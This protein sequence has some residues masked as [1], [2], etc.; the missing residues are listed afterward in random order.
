MLG[1]FHASAQM[2]VS[3]IVFDI[4]K[5][6]YVEN[7]KV[8]ST[9]GGF[10]L[11]DSMGR[12]HILVHKEDSLYFFYNNKPTL[13]FAVSQI[14][15]P[16]QFNIS[17]SLAVKSKYSLLKE[18]TVIA[19]SYRE[20][21]IENRETYSNVFNFT[22]PGLQS[23]MSPDGIPGAD[24]GALINVFRFRYSKRMRKFRERLEAQEQEKYVDYRFNKTFVRRITGLQPPALDT[25]MAWYRPDYHFTR[26]ADELAFNQYILNSLYHFRKIRGGGA[27][28]AK[29]E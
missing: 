28:P 19:R 12:Y 17:L 25:F 29:K 11:T 23:S 22:K 4:S 26:E 8:V 10:V 5:V 1:A 3:G 21:S 20:D 2:T 27:P 9:G 6:N 13:K 16:N 7:V 18:V 14:P 24:L 15:D